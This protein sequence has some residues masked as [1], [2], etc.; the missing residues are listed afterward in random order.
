MLKL[1]TKARYAVR[2]MVELAAHEGEG[3]VHLASVAAAQGLSPKYLEQLAIPL[4]RAKLVRAVRGSAGGYQ[5]ARP[6]TAISIH[7]IMQAVDGPVELVTCV[8]HPKTCP[9]AP[10]CAAHGLWERLTQA[11]D[12]VLT[13]TTLAE[14]RADQSRVDSLVFGGERA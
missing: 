6:A 5:L 9:R 14:L 13:G 10:A 12:G 3:L 4:R 1:P 7:E 11:V 8:T 2:L